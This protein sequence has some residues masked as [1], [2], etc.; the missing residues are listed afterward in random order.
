M[1]YT[2]LSADRF[3]TVLA[4]LMILHCVCEGVCGCV[5]GC[6]GVYV[7]VCVGVCGCVGVGVINCIVKYNLFF[8]V[9]CDQNTDRSFAE[10]P[11][12]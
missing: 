7:G 8:A 6:V 10:R 1:V 3:E 4:R 12:C 5:G 11:R 9:K 2:G